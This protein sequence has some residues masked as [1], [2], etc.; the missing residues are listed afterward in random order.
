MGL[1]KKRRDKDFEVRQRLSKDI[2]A[3]VK[4]ISEAAIAFNRILEDKEQQHYS[5]IKAASLVV[6]LDALI[7]LAGEENTSMLAYAAGII[8][9]MAEDAEIAKNLNKQNK[10]KDQL[11]KEGKNVVVNVPKTIH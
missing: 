3:G 4:H 8:Q 7:K 11:L 2:Y 5:Q 6:A 9:G 1:I 10:V